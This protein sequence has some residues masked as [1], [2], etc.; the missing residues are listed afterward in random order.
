MAVVAVDHHLP[1]V[2]AL[3]EAD[4]AQGHAVVEAV[5]QDAQVVVGEQDVR[6]R[7]HRVKGEPSNCKKQIEENNNNKIKPYI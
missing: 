7:R 3:G 2:D 5:A 4:G 6:M 1:V